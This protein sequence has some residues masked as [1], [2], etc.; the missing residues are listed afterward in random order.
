MKL[1]TVRVT[2]FETDIVLYLLALLEWT[3][4]VVSYRDAN[5]L[6][7]RFS[8]YTAIRKGPDS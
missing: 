3:Y 5:C 6:Q 4:P 8:A 1:V 2:L 7:K